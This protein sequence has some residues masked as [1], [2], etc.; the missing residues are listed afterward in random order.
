MGGRKVEARTQREEAESLKA[1]QFF[2]QVN[3]AQKRAIAA[4]DPVD[5]DWGENG[6]RGGVEETPI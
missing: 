4:G 2:A 3:A 5:A 6:E 1:A